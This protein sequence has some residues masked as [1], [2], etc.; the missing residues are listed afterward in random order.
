MREPRFRFFA[1]LHPIAWLLAVGALL[2]A[3]GCSDDEPEEPA[4]GSIGA[5]CKPKSG[6][7][8]PLLCT[9][10]GDGHACTYPA[11]AECQPDD[12]EL[13]N[14][15]CALEAECFVPPDAEDE[16]TGTCLLLEGGECDPDEPFC[17]DEL[18]CAE[19]QSGGHR[20]YAPVLLVGTVRDTSDGSAI[21]GAHVIGIDAEG[22]AATTVSKTSADG[23]YE[24]ALPVPRDDDGR[25]LD[26][27]FTL[28]GSAQGYQP[29]P[30]GVR[31][32]LPISTGEAVEQDGRFVVESALTEIG[33]IPLP[34]GERHTISGTI[35]A[36]E[37]DAE[38]R[39]VSNVTGVLV[40]ASDGSLSFSAT[41]DRDG[42][43]TIFNVP[44]G[45]Y[46]VGAY[47]AGLQVTTES[48]GVNGEPV[49]G[50]TLN[51]DDRRTV[52]VSGNVQI[53]NAPGGA[54]TSVILVVAA[55]FDPDAA[56]GE[57]PRGL[58]AP[59]TGVPDVSG[60]F[61]IAGVPDGD[62]VV[63]AAYENDDLVRDPDTNIAGTDFVHLRVDAD[64]GASL[65]ISE[66]F[67]VTEAL[68][69]VGPGA[70][71]PEAV[72]DAPTLTWAD[73]SSE[74]WY[75]VR[76]FDAFGDE[77]WSDLDVPS[78]S[79]KGSVTV[80]YGGPLDPGMFYQFRVLSWRQPGNGM[81][82]PISA[83]EDLRGVFYVP[84]R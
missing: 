34:G 71:G 84:A 15:G 66:S 64:D 58:R 33:L 73:D 11:G 78:V 4:A 41:T 61:E 75:E 80:D 9:E 60:D 83:T 40:V 39:P 51:E 2:V 37:T 36:A 29:F 18:T 13:V 28:D 54:Q 77:V 20:C 52:T 59:R 5:S 23:Q 76:V 22:S 6:C 1:A 17:T 79:G 12:A 16:G 21:G 65:S 68:A 25:P 27:A 31:V 63:L 69:V 62:Y 24:L 82:A 74:D 26:V 57:V 48:V 38:G 8:E 50:V 42:T 81:A 72:N 55:T 19:M 45:D 70:E 44:N 56:R 67:K 43:F 32:A 35:R 46:E 3:T 7:L 14:G 53:V 10:V 47:A 49:E 30:S